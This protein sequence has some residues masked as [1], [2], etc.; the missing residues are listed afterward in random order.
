MKKKDLLLY[1]VDNQGQSMKAS[2]KPL[3]TSLFLLHPAIFLSSFK[4][5]HFLLINLDCLQNNYLY[6]TLPL[7]HHAIFTCFY[8]KMYLIL[9]LIIFLILKLNNIILPIKVLENS[10]IERLNET[11]I[12]FLFGFVCCLLLLLLLLFFVFCFCFSLVLFLFYQ[13]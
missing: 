9:I 12:G 5:E 8:Y 6:F 3:K 4:L 2:L 1:Q 11:Q 7:Q 10:V 13:G